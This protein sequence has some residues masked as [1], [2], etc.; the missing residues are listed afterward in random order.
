MCVKTVLGSIQ[1]CHMCWSV[2]E[3]DVIIAGARSCF[4]FDLCI[5]IGGTDVVIGL[6]SFVICFTN[7]FAFSL[8]TIPPGA[9]I[10]YKNYFRFSCRLQQFSLL[11]RVCGLALLRATSTELARL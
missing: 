4:C 6:F 5:L 7:L 2:P 8:P 3:V 11:R 1:L 10:H 9:G